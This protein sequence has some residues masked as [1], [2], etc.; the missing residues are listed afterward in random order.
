MSDIE[1]AERL[2]RIEMSQ[3]AMRD[4][5]QAMRDDLTT[6]FAEFNSFVKEDRKRIEKL[7]LDQARNHERV[8]SLTGKVKTWNITNSLGATIA[9][10]TA[11]FK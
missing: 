11:L 7:E 10:I 3:Q 2:V 1:L 4:S 9:F 8:E 5:Q 6:Y